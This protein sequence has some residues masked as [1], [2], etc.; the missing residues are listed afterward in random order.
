MLH[1]YRIRLKEWNGKKTRNKPI[2]I[3][4][5]SVWY[6]QHL[7]SNK[8]I[9]YLNNWI[10][11]S[12]WEKLDPNFT[13]YPK[14]NIKWIQIFFC[15]FVFKKKKHKK[16]QCTVKT[17]ENSIGECFPYFGWETFLKIAQNPE[18]KKEKKIKSTFKVLATIFFSKKL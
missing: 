17:L 12:K 6:I 13:L 16:N 5:F 18:A 1:E 7:K 9:W 15:L 10:V 8:V 14:I 11:I 3:W 2:Y 4:K